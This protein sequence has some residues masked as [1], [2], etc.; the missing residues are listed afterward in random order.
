MCPRPRWEHCDE[1]TK[2]IAAAE[3]KH[4]ARLVLWALSMGC[5]CCMRICFGLQKHRHANLDIY[6]FESRGITTATTLLLNSVGSP[7]T[8]RQNTM[9]DSLV[10]LY[11]CGFVQTKQMENYLNMYTFASRR[12][13]IDARKAQSHALSRSCSTEERRDA[14]MWVARLIQAKGLIGDKRGR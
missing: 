1:T 7:H 13:S 4:Y 3:L 14:C 2:N 11:V 12:Y 8:K 10:C 9:R 6:R 5:V